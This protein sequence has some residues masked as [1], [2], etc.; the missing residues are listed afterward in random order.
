M[1][2]GSGFVQRLSPEIPGL[3]APES[4]VQVGL[5]AWAGSGRRNTVISWPSEIRFAA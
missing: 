4:Q 2:S 3:L 5:V 1:N